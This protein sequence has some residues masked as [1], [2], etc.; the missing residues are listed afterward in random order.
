MATVTYRELADSYLEA[1]TLRERLER[2]LHAH[3]ARGAKPGNPEARRVA[4]ALIATE[5]EE[6]TRRR[7]MLAHP[8]APPQ[9]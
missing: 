7:V 3:I 8:D 6:A 4:D 2:S 9:G 5:R 1:K